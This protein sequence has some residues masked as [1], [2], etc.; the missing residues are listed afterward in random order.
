MVDAQREIRLSIRRAA[1][2]R[3]LGLAGDKLV[4]A[5][6]VFGAEVARADAVATAKNAWHFLRSDGRQIT[7]VL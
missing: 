3:A 6:R 1:P 5:K 7:A 2:V 4:R